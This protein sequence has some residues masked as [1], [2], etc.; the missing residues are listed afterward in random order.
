MQLSTGTFIT[1][2]ASLTLLTGSC[3]AR[4]TQTHP[5]LNSSHSGLFR[6]LP[7]S[8]ENLP[9]LQGW[10]VLHSWP[11]HM[12]KN[13]SFS[14]S[15]SLSYCHNLDQWKQL[16]RGLA[17]IKERGT[18]NRMFFVG[19]QSFWNWFLFPDPEELK[20]YG[21]HSMLHSSYF[22]RVHENWGELQMW[23][24]SGGKALF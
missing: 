5:L 6:S 15:L 2:A 8:P 7:G 9:F 12:W 21:L 23:L 1:T 19:T 24:V 16:S 18:A 3:I 14:L 10:K 11:W 20:F 4:A 17:G 13:F 22:S